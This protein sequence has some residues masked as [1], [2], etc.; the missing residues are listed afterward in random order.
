MAQDFVRGPSVKALIAHLNEDNQRRT[1]RT[2]YDAKLEATRIHEFIKGGAPLSALRSYD[3][4][5]G[6]HG[7][8][9]IRS[10]AGATTYYSNT[11][12]SYGTTLLYSP[13]KSVR[14]GDW[15]S[16]VE[17]GGFDGLGGGRRS[18]RLLGGLSFCAGAR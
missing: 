6:N 7:I 3:R 14:I 16:I 12:D 1:A 13:G 9:S 15:A 18:S 17:R 5:V 10:R 2:A 4:L 8:E 11:G